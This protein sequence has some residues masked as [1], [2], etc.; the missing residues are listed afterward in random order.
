MN[1]WYRATWPSG[2][3]VA[4][5]MRW[6]VSPR[7]FKS[8]RCRFVLFRATDS[9]IGSAF[10][11]RGLNRDQ[12]VVRSSRTRWIFV[13]TDVVRDN[14]MVREEGER[15]EGLQRLLEFLECEDDGD[16]EDDADDAEGG[17]EE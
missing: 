8:H 6:A 15:E 4:L 3:G 13:M 7:V 9:T 12:K 10:D 2:E 1:M 16:E 17:L 5:E 14:R 11:C